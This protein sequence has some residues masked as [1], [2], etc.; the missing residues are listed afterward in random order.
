MAT[1]RRTSFVELKG[2]RITVTNHQNRQDVAR[3]LRRTRDAK[4]PII[5]DYL[6][7]DVTDLQGQ[8]HLALDL[9]DV[10]QVD[11]AELRLQWSLAL[12]GG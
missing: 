8:Y 7:E 1:E 9:K 5:S 6:L 12:A 11:D 4:Q 3:L 10:L 2:Q